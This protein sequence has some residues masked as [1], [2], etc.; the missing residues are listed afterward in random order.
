MAKIGP[1]LA[2]RF[3]DSEISWLNKLA[4]GSVKILCG[5]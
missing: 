5:L 4:Q 3:G 1:L 2:L